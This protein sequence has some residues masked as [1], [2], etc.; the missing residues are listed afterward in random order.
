MKVQYIHLD[1]E[2]R[3]KQNYSNIVNLEHNLIC[4]FYLRAEGGQTLALGF[5]KI[6]MRLLSVI[7]VTT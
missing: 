6:F 7:K 4:K 3:K 5:W 1:H 2:K